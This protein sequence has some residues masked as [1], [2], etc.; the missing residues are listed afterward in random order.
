MNKDREA[1]I[2]AKLQEKGANLPCPRCGQTSFTLLD[3]YLNLIVQ[4][5]L[6]GGLVIGGPTVPSAVTAC[7]NCGY[8]SVHA[9]GVLG[10][11]EK[12]GDSK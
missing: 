4:N 3:S 11:L 10:L 6:S 9:L 1:E 5:E 8:L 12:K 2:I 7:N